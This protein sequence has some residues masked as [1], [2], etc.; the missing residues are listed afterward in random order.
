M[1]TPVH[2]HPLSADEEPPSRGRRSRAAQEASTDTLRP[3]NNYFSLKAQLEK[4]GEADVKSISSVAGSVV[5]ARPNWD[6][7][8]RAYGKADWPEPNGEQ[9]VL[10][11]RPSSASFSPPWQRSPVPVQ[12]P[13]FVGAPPCDVSYV[14]PSSPISTRGNQLFE[15]GTSELSSSLVAQVL[16]NTWHN[17]SDEAIQSAI[18]HLEAPADIE[19]HPYHAALRVLSSAFHHVSRTCVELEERRKV[20]EEKQ[21]AAKLRAEAL[22]EDLQPSEREVARRVIQSIFTDDDEEKHHV[23]R[24]QS[25]TSLKT[26]LTEALEDEVPLARSLPSDHNVPSVP[27]TSFRNKLVPANT[28]RPNS[29]K[30][31]QDSGP[32]PGVA[33]T[34]KPMPGNSTSNEAST[35]RLEAPR[36]E[37]GSIGEWVG[38]WLQRSK[39][40]PQR[41][42]PEHSTKEIAGSGN[43]SRDSAHSGGVIADVSVTHPSDQPPRIHK[44]A[45]RSVFETLGISVLNPTMPSMSSKQRLVTKQAPDPMLVPP[46]PVEGAKTPPA[47]PS[48]VIGTLP[49]PS[50][51]APQLAISHE[52]AEVL[53][54]TSTLQSWSLLEEGPLPQGASL[55]AIAHA[56]RVMTTDPGSILVDKGRGTCPLVRRLAFELVQNAKEERIS[57][58]ELPKLRERRERKENKTE[59]G[60]QVVARATLAPLEGVDAAASLT[61]AL[62]ITQ[63]EVRKSKLRKGTSPSFTSPI[64]SALVPQPQRKA[65]IATEG[66]AKYTEQGSS[67]SRQANPVLVHSPTTK[68]RSVPLESIIPAIAKPPTQY[69]SRKYPSLT[70]PDFHFTIPLPNSASRFDIYRDRENQEPLTD[71]YGFIYDVCLYDLM[72]LIRAKECGNT[73]PACLTGVKIADRK[74]NNS[75]SDEEEGSRGNTMDI[76]KGPCNC[77]GLSPPPSTDTT[78]RRQNAKRKEWDTFVKQRTEVLLA[79]STLPVAGATTTT[80]G[81][82]VLLGLGTKDEEEELSHT[83]GLVGFAQLGLSSN[84]DGRREF[85]RLVRAGIPLAYRSKLWLECSGGLEMREP[86]LFADLLA[87]ADEHELVSTE[88]EKDVGRTMPLNIFFGG[89]GAGVTKLRRVLTAY[90]RRNP[91]VGYCQGMNLVTSTLLLIHADEEEAFWVLC[92]IIERILPEDFFSPSLLPSRACPLVLLDYVQEYLPK[93]FSHLSDLETAFQ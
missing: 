68:P 92:A 83:E 52:V 51:A 30:T 70:A 40:K 14:I 16:A 6:S 7:S 81:A 19:G 60:R 50:P 63:G 23:K 55:K 82:A 56:I 54:D 2:L 26:S 32:T 66:A 74:E 73:A 48:P 46:G 28:G 76:V 72:L 11:R 61:R 10:E 49:M 64:F 9:E 59:S 57:F 31:T 27:P 17:Y 5:Y 25:L 86:G 1:S 38:G 8:V 47:H 20:L 85:D 34:A 35:N 45:S 15:G 78:G 91:V 62:T 75:W 29:G 93:L 67:S 43:T 44:K 24:Q 12:A 3:Q 22:L 84:R 79:K 88:I 69:L 33:S 4:L 65:S 18:S 77:D 71:R 13:H 42:M 58:R 39:P 90:S 21:V 41:S 36:H 80:G 89:D 37:R 87:Q 53:A